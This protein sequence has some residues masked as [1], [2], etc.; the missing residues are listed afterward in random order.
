[1]SACS[2]VLVIAA[3]LAVAIAAGSLAVQQWGVL[4]SPLKLLKPSEARKARAAGMMSKWH[5]LVS[6]ASLLA[7]KL[8]FHNL[9]HR[10]LL[11]ATRN[12][13]QLVR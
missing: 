5:P 10:P 9:K 12:N 6:A 11:L 1:M 8:T 2:L 3:G 4:K 13:Q 7:T